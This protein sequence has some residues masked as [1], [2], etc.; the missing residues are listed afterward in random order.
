MVNISFSE[1][2][3]YLKMDDPLHYWAPYSDLRRIR[4]YSRIQ[5]NRIYQQFVSSPHDKNP[6]K[7]AYWHVF[8]FSYEGSKIFQTWG[9]SPNFWGSSPNDHFI[10]EVKFGDDQLDM[11][12]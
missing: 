3:A 4:P 12:S 11:T 6:C 7:A 9:S 2:F 5:L 8:T 1:N 10:L